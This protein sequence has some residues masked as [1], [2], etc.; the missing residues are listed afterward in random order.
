MEDLEEI[1]ELKALW[2]QKYSLGVPSKPS[3]QQKS[4]FNDLKAQ[5]KSIPSR[6]PTQTKRSYSNFKMLAISTAAILIIGFSITFLQQKKDIPLDW[7]QI[8]SLSEQELLSHID[9]EVLNEYAGDIEE[10]SDL[11]TETN[12]SDESLEEYLIQTKIPIE[13]LQ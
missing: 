12:F 13:Y 1:K 11:M 6:N 4:E 9:V 5:L 7:T 8:D 10:Y 2:K 3:S